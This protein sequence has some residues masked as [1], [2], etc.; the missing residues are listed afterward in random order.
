MT[1]G[2]DL[3]FPRHPPPLFLG[4]GSVFWLCPAALDKQREGD[5]P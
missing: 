3:P 4:E 5:P 2:V 1:C